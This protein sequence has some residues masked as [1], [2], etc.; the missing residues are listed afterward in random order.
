MDPYTDIII[1]EKELFS[2]SAIDRFSDMFRF[3]FNKVYLRM[4][5]IVMLLM[6][7]YFFFY[8]EGL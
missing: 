1:Y 6:D 2:A 5:F 3:L 7:F 4:V 8:T